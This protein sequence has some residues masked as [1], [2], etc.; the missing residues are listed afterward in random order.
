[1]F[2][3]FTD[4][5]LRGPTLGCML[6]C[7]SASLMGVVVFLKKRSLLGEAL[8]HAAYP[9]VVIGMGLSACFGA[10]LEGGSLLFALAGA[11]LFSAFGF[12][13]IDWMEKKGRVSPDAALCFML[14]SFFGLGVLSLS[15]LQGAYPVFARQVQLYLYG[16]AATMTD[17]HIAVYGALSLLVLGFLASVYRP[18][19]AALFDPPFARAAGIGS[20]F[21]SPALF[22]LLLLSIIVGIRSVGVI[23]MSGMLIAPAVAARQLT[24]RLGTLFFLAGLFG[25][26]SG[27]LGNWA[28][29]EG[30]DALA[31]LFPGRRLSLPTGPMIVLFGSLFALLS[32][33]F[34][35]K[36]GV[37]ARMF[38]I[39]KFRLRCVEE[40]ILKAV[41]KRESFPIGE[42]QKT[43]HVSLPV[44]FW[45]LFR[46]RGEG[47]ISVSSGR[48]L[49]LTA[50]GKRRASR[51][52]RLHRLWEVYL[53]ELGW[54]E[55]RVHQGAEEM[56][57]ILTAEFGERLSVQLSNPLLDPH[58]QPIPEKHG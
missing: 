14:A 9:G 21:L 45:I 11:L 48:V 2:D 39:L 35:P 32:L 46:M 52:V 17:L 19:Q 47:W 23:L 27:F 58:A 8:S 33:L 20:R 12:K 41:W 44:F 3:Y 25:V 42:L 55:D 15:W 10:A 56:E 57:H 40:N 43:Q 53:S 37:A 31:M 24:N 38:R 49:T 13:A 6:M 30:S 36:R 18:L 34:A 26:A 51:I 7:L 1:M 54:P 5:I 22:F 50:D 29:A 28:S 16:Q 4:P